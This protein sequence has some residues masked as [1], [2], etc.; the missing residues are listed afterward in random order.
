MRELLPVKQ[1][2]KLDDGKAWPA[3][4]WY[5]CCTENRCR[6]L[7]QLQKQV[8]FQKIHSIKISMCWI[9]S[10]LETRSSLF[11]IEGPSCLRSPIMQCKDC[12]CRRRSSS[13]L[14]FPSSRQAMRPHIGKYS[15]CGIHTTNC[16]TSQLPVLFSPLQIQTL[17]TRTN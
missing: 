17:T 7:L 14:R 12:T 15:I 9:G 3:D 8:C 11:S 16:S 5:R 10:E 6:P 2:L 1:Q 13:T 4:G